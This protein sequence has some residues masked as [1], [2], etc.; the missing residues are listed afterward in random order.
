MAKPQEIRRRI[1]SIESTGKIT[2][3]MEMVS[4]SKLR[5]AQSAI[6][7]ARPYTE[8]MVE[9][10]GD[11]ARVTGEGDFPLLQE[12][13]EE[14]VV[15]VVSLTADRGFTGA[16]NTNVLRRS[17]GLLRQIKED[18]KSGQLICIGKKGHSYF[19]FRHYEILNSYLDVT[20]GPTY[21]TAKQIAIELMD[22]YTEGKVDKVE[23]VYNRFKSAMEQVDTVQTVL[24][25]QKPEVSEADA[26]SKFATD[27][28]F[29]P[30]PGE[31]FR[32]IL[33]AYVETQIFR[34]LL[35]SSASEQ[36]ARMT[37]MK[38]A[39]DNATEII[40]NLV[41]TLNRARQAQITQEISEI[42][43]GAE[44]LKYSKS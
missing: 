10:I 34:A 19:S 35:E 11:L 2:R 21:D 6:E 25:I 22:L 24:P 37:A 18:G 1:K 33:P 9:F 3:A 28:L 29:E 36:G 5:R 43:G 20:D 27:Y 13:E 12:H 38:K 31:L 40:S 17:E 8:K 23:L 30:S 32:S 7:M 39:S 44:S 14:K 16:F 15:C 4:A 41:L 42:V 26:M